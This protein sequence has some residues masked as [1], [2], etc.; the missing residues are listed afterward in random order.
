MIRRSH[1]VLLKLA[2]LLAAII[3][4]AC[5]TTQSPKRQVDDSAIHAAVKARLTTSHFSNITNVDVNVTNGV[6]TLSGQVPNEQIKKDAEDEAKKVDGVVSVNNNLQ[7]TG[8]GPAASRAIST[9]PLALARSRA[10][11]S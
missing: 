2:A 11:G 9:P 1:S 10:L 3:F 6:V 5:S 8:R 7:V 4:A